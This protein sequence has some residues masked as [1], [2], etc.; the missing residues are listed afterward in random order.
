MSA[1]EYRTRGSAEPQGK[2]NIYL[3]CHPDDFDRCFSEMTNDLLQRL[4]AAVWYCGDT[5][6]DDE[7]DDALAQM[8]LIVI[9]VTAKLLTDPCRVTEI[10]LPL[11]EKSYIPVLPVLWEELPYE[12]YNRMFGSLQFLDKNSADPTQIDYGKKLDNYLNKVLTD[13]SLTDQIRDA[14]DAYIFLSYRKKDRKHA[15]KLMR[16]I[17][18]NPFCRDVAV[19]YDEYLVPGRVFSNDIR[20]AMRRSR[21]FA[22]TVTPNLL[23]ENNYVMTEEYPDALA[24]KM[25]ILPVELE[26]TDRSMLKRLYRGLPP[27]VECS[28][29]EGLDAALSAVASREIKKEPRHLFFMGL[30][31][32]NGIDMEVDRERGIALI[33]EA[34]D[35]ELPEAIEQLVAVY[36][37]GVGAQRD[38]SK[39]VYYQR[40]LVEHFRDEYERSNTAEAAEAL[41]RKLDE[42]YIM[43][44]DLRFFE[45]AQESARQTLDI[46]KLWKGSGEVFDLF[47]ACAEISL[48]DI[49]LQ[50]LR[51]VEAEKRFAAAEEI[52]NSVSFEKYLSNARY[53]RMSL[54]N[55]RSYAAQID[56]RYDD[57]ERYIHAV[58]TML[59]ESL[60]SEDVRAELAKCLLQSG[61]IAAQ[62]GHLA[63]AVTC[64][65][66]AIGLFR[67]ICVDHTTISNRLGV[68]CARI[69]LVSALS[70]TGEVSRTMKECEDICSKLADIEKTY[71]TYITRF[72]TAQ[73][74]EAAGDAAFFGKYYDRARDYYWQSLEIQRTLAEEYDFAE[75]WRYLNVTL[76]KAAHLESAACNPRGAI[77]CFNESL[78]VIERLVPE[79]DAMQTKLDLAHTL[80][81]LGTAYHIDNDYANAEKHFLRALEICE[82]LT[83]ESY[84][85]P[86]QR[87]YYV[88]LSKLAEL[89]INLGRRRE[90]IELY[91]DCQAMAKKD[92][93]ETNDINSQINFA[94]LCLRLGKE[95]RDLKL[96]NDAKKLY[97]DIYHNHPEMTSLKDNINMASREII[98][99]TFGL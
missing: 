93:T 85:A 54:N 66:K 65:E 59:E 76:D 31:Y 86:I 3:T 15:Q 88:C 36:L 51:P 69:A 18:D 21:L 32:L 72:F 6:T 20:E 61:V 82:T 35:R 24:D 16:L 12:L 9:P 46:S 55:R 7:Y 19:W 34:A 2:I 26:P 11:A 45:D 39:A 73:T 47:N 74:L 25:D 37:N 92:V 27:V 14:F 75:A 49:E 63:R 94:F 38:E 10:D 41:L 62:A 84:A 28:D 42:E 98:R 95:T 97:M 1:F 78:S 43:L 17:H 48:G 77:S 70:K 22:L 80:Q 5:E 44:Y 79:T 96:L 53:A 56:C 50:N 67:K 4:D 87:Q 52:L 89:Y 13:D 68:V 33:T 91:R 83:E 90:G 40:R 81:E 58:Q 29:R 99:V 71:E 57:A 64:Y 8:Q 30:A 60:D 23:E